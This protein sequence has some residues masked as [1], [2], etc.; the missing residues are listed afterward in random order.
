ME[1]RVIIHDRAKED[2]RRNSRWWADHHS[3]SQAEKWF[4]F[5]FDSMEKLAHFPESH[6]IAAESPEFP[7][8]I[9]ELNFGLGS[10]PG[11][12]ALFA[13]QSN[14]VHVLTIRRAAEDRVSAQD[15]RLD[16]LDT[17]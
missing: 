10:R 15:L 11:Y 12:R 3:S 17:E 1:Y 7:V 8:E 6:P 13:I 4:H 16:F 2:I 14:D 9:R 5:A